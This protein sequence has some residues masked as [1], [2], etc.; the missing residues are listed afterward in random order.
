MS[1]KNAKQYNKKAMIPITI[2]GAQASIDASTIPEKDWKHCH[3]PTKA[4]VEVNSLK[5]ALRG[6]SAILER[7]DGFQSSF[8]QDEL[9]VA[10]REYLTLRGYNIQVPTLS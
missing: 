2:G 10:A 9:E 7:Q 4:G 1:K 6:D 8:G 5:L 3:G